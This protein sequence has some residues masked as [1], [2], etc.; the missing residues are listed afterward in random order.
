MKIL[1]TGGGGFLGRWIVDK[2]LGRGDTVRVL[3]RR[4]YPDLAERGVETVQA[5]VMDRD[6]AASACEGIDAVFH[7]ASRVGVWGPRKDFLGVNVTGTENVIAGCRSCGVGRL[8]YTS[9]PSV[10]YG[11]D[12]IEGGDETLSYPDDYLAF[13]PETKAIAERAVIDANGTDGLLT[14]SLRPHIIWGPGDTN[15]I[16]RL[17]ERARSGRLAQVGDGTNR[18]S[19]IYVENAADAHLCACDRLV[20]GSTVP[21]QC[22]FITES[23]PVNCWKFIGELLEALD[24]PP[25]Q[26]T[27]SLKTAYRMGAVL[28]GIYRLFGIAREPMMTRF[29]ALQLATSHWF[30]TSKARRDLGWESKVSVKE[31]IRRLGNT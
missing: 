18:I 7:T 20:D 10:V 17:V 16:P 27:V 25:V 3:G 22:Y 29:T 31:G 4:E 11:R 12:P 24:C 28:E 9:T 26:K 1:V 13:Y 14:C 19:V 5:D 6:A 8:V 21:G 23:E 15:L 30:D 2:L